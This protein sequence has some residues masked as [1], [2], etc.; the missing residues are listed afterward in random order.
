MSYGTLWPPS[1]LVGA[2]AVAEKAEVT[3]SLKDVGPMKAFVAA[4]IQLV[5]EIE[6]AIGALEHGDHLD[7]QEQVAGELRD[8]VTEFRKA[9]DRG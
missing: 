5:G 3:I 9:V 6:D 4:T 2:E 8:A 7:T 1:V